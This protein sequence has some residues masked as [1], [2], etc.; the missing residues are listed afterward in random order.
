MIP[1][2]PWWRGEGI[3]VRPKEIPCSIRVAGAVLAVIFLLNWPQ[4]SGQWAVWVQAFGAILALAIAVHLSA[5][6]RATRRL[7]REQDRHDQAHAAAYDIATLA[8]ELHMHIVQL[9]AFSAEDR[10]KS[11]YLAEVLFFKDFQQRLSKCTSGHA[12]IT[13]KNLGLEIRK[14]ALAATEYV[15]ARSLDQKPQEP[16]WITLAETA[17]RLF[18]QAQMA[19]PRTKTQTSSP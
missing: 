6:E 16:D 19:I 17:S 2:A 4:D 18:D 5:Q 11:L 1:S 14:L 3:N 9:R 8:V 10:D 15:M 7:E 12:P 13:Q